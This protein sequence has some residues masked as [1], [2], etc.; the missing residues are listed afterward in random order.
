MYLPPLLKDFVVL[1]ENY[2]KTHIE[3]DEFPFHPIFFQFQEN[4]R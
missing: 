1:R 4:K 2:K 3:T